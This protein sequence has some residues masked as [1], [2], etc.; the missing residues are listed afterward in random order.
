MLETN[1]SAPLGEF[2][3]ASTITQPT[4][5]DGTTSRQYPEHSAS[6]TTQNDLNAQGTPRARRGAPHPSP[7][8]CRPGCG[9]PSPT[10]DRR[11][12]VSVADRRGPLAVMADLGGVVIQAGGEREDDGL[13]DLGLPLQSQRRRGSFSTASSSIQSGAKDDEQDVDEASNAIPAPSFRRVPPPHYAVSM[14]YYRQCPDPAPCEAIAATAERLYMPHYR[15][16]NSSLERRHYLGEFLL[17]PS[18]R[19]H[20]RVPSMKDATR[21][22]FA[23]KFVTLEAYVGSFISQCTNAGDIECEKE[24]DGVSSVAANHST[25]L[26]VRVLPRQDTR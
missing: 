14:Y 5:P 25:S 24:G 20:A 4:P 23:A 10:G 11:K 1:S 21:R 19:R 13:G 3:A 6:W 16:L 9:L 26:G 15:N 17:T 22:D 18:R 8:L 12:I 2:W 7:A